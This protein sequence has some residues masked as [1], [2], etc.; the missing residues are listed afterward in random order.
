MVLSLE[1]FEGLPR[2]LE[3]DVFQCFDR[4]LE[5][6][7]VAE[8]WNRVDESEPALKQVPYPVTT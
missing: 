2:R 3:G 6:A 4:D 7:L 5:G 8:R 1:Q